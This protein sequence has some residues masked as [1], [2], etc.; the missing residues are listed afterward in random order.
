MQSSLIEVGRAIGKTSNLPSL[1]GRFA[2]FISQPW[3]RPG[4]VSKIVEPDRIVQAPALT[5]GSAG[6]K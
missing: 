5:G 1:E 2:A 4:N 6:V 3:Y